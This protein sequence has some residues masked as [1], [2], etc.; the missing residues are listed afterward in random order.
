[1]RN[2][3]KTSVLSHLSL[4][5]F[6]LPFALASCSTDNHK[7]CHTLKFNPDTVEVVTGQT[8]AVKISGGQAPYTAT[9]CD[10]K[11]A[12]VKVDK[13]TVVITATEPG[14]VMIAVTDKNKITGTITVTVK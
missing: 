12:T 2:L 6:T 3:K 14:T 1:M 10:A 11:T 9:L 5:A 4:L 13:D 7:V 8:V